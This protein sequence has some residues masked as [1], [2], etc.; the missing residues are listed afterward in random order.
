VVLLLLLAI[1][2]W[3]I[4]PVAYVA[5]QGLTLFKLSSEFIICSTLMIAGALLWVSRKYFDK[6]VLF[7]ILLSLGFGILAEMSLMLYRDATN[8]FY[9][10]GHLFYIVSFF[11]IYRAITVTGLLQ[12]YNIL[13]RNL[14]FS[15]DLLQK[16]RDKLQNLLDLEESMLVALDSEGKVTLINRKGQEIIQAREPEILGKPWFDAYIPQNISQT[17]REDYM[18]LMNGQRELDK[19]TNRPV[20]T[21]SGEE[22][23]I[24]WHNELLKDETGKIIGTFSSGQD[25]TRRKQAEQL[26]QAIFD[27][28]PIGMYISQDRSFR[29]VNPQ[30]LSYTEYAQ[31]E[32]IGIDPLSLVVPEDQVGVRQNAIKALKTPAGQFYTYDYRVKTK[33]GKLVW[34]ME[35]ITSIQFDGRR[36]TLGTIIDVSERKQSEEL[37]KSLS[38]IDDLTGLYNRR[39]FLTLAQKQLKLSNRMNRGVTVL[40]ADVD[41]LKWINDNLGHLEGDSALINTAKILKDTFRESDI[42]GRI[43]GDEFAVFMSG[44]DEAYSAT[45]VSRLQ[46][47]IKEFNTVAKPAYILSLSIGISSSEAG[48]TCN[49]DDLLE[50]ADKFMYEKKREG[51]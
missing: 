15:R 33:S 9:M 45:I 25:I 41:K 36:A 11:L 51:R 14:A 47:K 34:F 10:L 2:L 16:E 44:S 37:F 3:H 49:L 32:L 50:M 29:L 28:S 8:L 6:E 20:L 48:K 18:K 7:Y 46:S 24:A 12:P 42:V 35:S 30:L 17:A 39:G 31:H 27:M 1:L 21:I 23:L 40:F 38:L 4:F 43:H 22:R 13:F 26:F 19:Y 5:G